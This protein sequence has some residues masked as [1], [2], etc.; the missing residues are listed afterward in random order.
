MRY[1]SHLLVTVVVG[2]VFCLGAAAAK[3]RSQTVAVFPFK[4]LNK[5][6]RAAHL[7]EG[8]SEHIITHLV[9]SNAIDIV[10][11]AQLDKA[12]RR[13]ANAQ[14]GVFEESNALQLGKMVNARFVIIGTVELFGYQVAINSRLLEVETGKLIIAES[15]HGNVDSI[16][17]LYEKLAARLKESLIHHLSMLVTSSAVAERGGNSDTVNIIELISRGEKLDPAY[18]GKDL[19]GANMAY[20]QAV[21]RDPNSAAARRRLASTF[22]MMERF[23]EAKYNLDKAIAM[24][25]NNAWAQSRLGYCLHR[26]GQESDALVAY[27]KSLEINPNDVEARAWYASSLL[28]LGNYDDARANFAEVLKRDPKNTVAQRGMRF[29]DQAVTQANKK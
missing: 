10:E 11:E 5:D 4:V 20:R 13:L 8:A 15:I 28:K 27:S 7:G 22:I 25:P 24:E 26:L 2:L 3:E 12:I 14:T 18:G 9:Q 1:R 21:L 29:I 16:F 19:K 23:D 6:P 17:E